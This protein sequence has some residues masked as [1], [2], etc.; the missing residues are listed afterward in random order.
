[1]G[2]MLIGVYDCLYAAGAALG[3]ANPARAAAFREE[4]ADAADGRYYCQTPV[5]IA[6]WTRIA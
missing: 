5:L 3:L 2:A 6:A 4:M 1:M